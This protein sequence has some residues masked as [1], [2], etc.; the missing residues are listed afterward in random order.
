M[1]AGSWVLF[2]TFLLTPPAV[3]WVARRGSRLGF[4][5]L[6]ISSA[7]PGTAVS[8]A[9]ALYYGG[10]W[11]CPGGCAASLAIALIVCWYRR[12]RRR[13]NPAGSLSDVARRRIGAMLRSLRER[14]VRRP[15]LQPAPRAA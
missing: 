15:G 2:A 13:R 12:N 11:N 8:A 7:A 14:S 1:S 9:G 6:W 10:G 4:V 3:A 5:G